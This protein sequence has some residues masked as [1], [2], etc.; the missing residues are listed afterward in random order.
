[1]KSFSFSGPR[2][3][4][5]AEERNELPTPMLDI[6]EPDYKVEVEI[7]AKGSVLWVNVDGFCCLRICKIKEPIKVNFIGS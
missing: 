3:D 4:R 6:T 1:M 7:N 5:Q 2:S